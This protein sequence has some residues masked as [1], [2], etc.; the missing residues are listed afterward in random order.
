MSSPQQPAT[1]PTNSSYQQQ[2]PYQPAGSYQ[3]PQNYGQPTQYYSQPAAGM[4]P[5]GI[6]P[7]AWQG[8]SGPMPNQMPM[9]QM[10][11]QG[12]IP[13]YDPNAQMMATQAQPSAQLPP[14]APPS[15]GYVVD[16][17]T[18]PQPKTTGIS[19]S[20]GWRSAIALRCRLQSLEFGPAHT[21]SVDRRDVERGQYGCRTDGPP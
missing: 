19:G 4:M 6:P 21:L 13:G 16:T 8:K 2:T 20:Q 18:T 3:P 17:E 12:N 5:Q 11:P 7:I 1:A 10:A 9:M 14:P 15:E